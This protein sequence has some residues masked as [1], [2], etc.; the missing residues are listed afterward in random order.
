MSILDDENI[1]IE[2]AKLSIK[3]NVKALLKLNYL[4]ELVEYL[5][6]VMY[7]KDY[8][9][10]VMTYPYTGDNMVVLVD[11]VISVCHLKLNFVIEGTSSIEE[12]I[13]F[14]NHLSKYRGNK[15]EILNK[16]DI[17]QDSNDDFCIFAL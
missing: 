3:D 17:E 15:I 4:D 11:G 2:R 8:Q 12:P 16:L 14:F 5:N 13:L 10:K 1:L 9:W 7:V 6:D